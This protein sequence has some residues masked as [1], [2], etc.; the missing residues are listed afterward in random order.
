MRRRHGATRALE[1][2][3]SAAPR[4]DGTCTPSAAPTHQ[5][6][7]DGVPVPTR[8][9]SMSSGAS[10]CRLPTLR[11]QSEP[12]GFYNPCSHRPGTDNNA[13]IVRTIAAS[14]ADPGAASGMVPDP[15]RRGR[16]RPVLPR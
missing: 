1:R 15:H 9:A 3:C 16:R 14:H 5:R 4:R 12:A 10:A 13:K 7:P 11:G 6:P 2:C 8:F